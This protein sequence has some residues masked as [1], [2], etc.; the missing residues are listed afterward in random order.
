[1]PHRLAANRSRALSLVA[2]LVALVVVGG[3]L[4]G[5]VVGAVAGSIA[6][7]LAVGALAGLLVGGV[8]AA[9][10]WWRSEDVVLS[11]SGARLVG[12]DEQ[13]RLHNL[14]DGLCATAG[15]PMPR[16]YVVDDP[17][18][19]S[20]SVGRGPDHAAVV[21]T[22]GALDRLGRVE[23]EGLVAHELSHVRTG[24]VLPATLA[25]TVLG[26]LLPATGAALRAVVGDDRERQADA[27]AVA[28]T[29]YPPGLVDALEKL[30]ADGASTAAIRR[31][32]AHLWAEAPDS[33]LGERIAALREL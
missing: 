7:G 8:L 19:N 16:L 1:M 20:C 18:A 11:L 28:L 6:G 21:V 5:L 33:D 30:R 23:L 10:A 15:L 3:A 24:D 2:A 13:P 29:R 14:V 12:R 4:V 9:V 32:T 17:T 31:A 27:G 22:T 26:F 25:A